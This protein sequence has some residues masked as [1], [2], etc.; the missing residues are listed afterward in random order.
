MNPGEQL[1][2]VNDFA[3][4]SAIPSVRFGT[5]SDRYAGWIGQIYSEE[6]RGS[7]SKRKRTLGGQRFEERTVPVASVEE[8]FEHFSTLEIDF[9]FYRPLL[10]AD[11]AP[12]SNYFVLQRYAD[13]APRSAEFILK[14]PQEV[15]ARVLR[16]SGAGGASSAAGPAYEANP[17]FLDSEIF[18][19]AYV[20]PAIKILGSRFIGILFEQEY[21]RKG[22][23]LQ[24]ERNITE[25]DRFFS[26]M[27]S[28]PQVHIELRS[29]HLLT[30][31]YF[32]W[33]ENRGIG[34]VFSHWT[35]L[36]SI[37]EQWRLSGKRFTASNRDVVCRLL[38][39]RKM[40]YA[41]AYAFAHPFDAPVPELS[42]TPQASAMLEDTTHLAIESLKK[43]FAPI[44]IS[45]NRAWGNAPSLAQQVA[46]RIIREME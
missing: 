1:D 24:S 3:F 9:T 32:D 19:N 26:S 44:I 17:S 43:D 46:R 29:P 10:A 34:H 11:G 4:R 25:F 45:N 12:T 41:K 28:I 30:T 5:A 38:T 20:S 16:R 6:W 2:R 18:I 40:Q 21:Q 7:V 39:P 27:Q 14:A 33:L 42:E 35:W 36:P 37:E 23:G 13:A 22:S 8:Y 31:P 15:S